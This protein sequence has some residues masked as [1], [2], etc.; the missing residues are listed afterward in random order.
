MFFH[1]ISIGYKILGSILA[2][3][4]FFLIGNITMIRYVHKITGF[5]LN[6][7]KKCIF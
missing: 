4:Q 2:S 1:Y 3:Y 6:Q 5:I 7:Q